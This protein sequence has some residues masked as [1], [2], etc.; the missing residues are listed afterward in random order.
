M[1]VVVAM[2]L[3]FASSLLIN[4]I[5]EYVFSSRFASA[6]WRGFV[7]VLLNFTILFTL[8]TG[9]YLFT[10]T[11]RKKMSDCA[12]MSLITSVAFLVGNML[13]GLYMKTI[14]IDSLYGAAGALLIF[15]L[16]TYYSSM[17]LFMSVEIF[18]FIKRKKAP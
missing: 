18:E 7:Q 10:P 2:C 4:P 16:W 1:L 12:Q 15:L 17:T 13:T 6:E 9:L 5:F 11:K 8:F 14:A 3:L